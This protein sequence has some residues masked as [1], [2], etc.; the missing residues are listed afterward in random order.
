MLSLTQ[1]R[2]EGR[3][4]PPFSSRPVLLMGED[5]DYPYPAPREINGMLGRHESW[6]R[7]ISFYDAHLQ[8]QAPT[9]R[10]TPD[11]AELD[12]DIVGSLQEH[13]SGLATA[14]TRSQ[15]W[16]W[17]T[18]ARNGGSGVAQYQSTAAR[19]AR[20]HDEAGQAAGP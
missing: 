6:L 17:P 12:Q 11:V 2:G 13:P 7:P 9:T 20:C 5:D 14:P 19:S 8:S 15:R 16:P 10:S 3:G 1:L 18:L 4:A